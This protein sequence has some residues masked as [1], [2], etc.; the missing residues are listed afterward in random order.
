MPALSSSRSCAALGCFAQCGESSK[1]VGHGCLERNQAK[2]VH[3]RSHPPLIWVVEPEPCE[4]N[5]DADQWLHDQDAGVPVAK[6]R[7]ASQDKE[8]DYLQ[9]E[10][11]GVGKENNA[12]DGAISTLCQPLARR[13]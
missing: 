5:E 10:R 12:I 1:E 4:A 11:D 9:G 3:A 8:N 7:E 13:P 6:I 2:N